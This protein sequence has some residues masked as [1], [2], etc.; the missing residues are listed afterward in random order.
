MFCFSS[1]TIHCFFI[2]LLLLNSSSSFTWSAP[3]LC[4][5][6]AQLLLSSNNSLA[7]HCSTYFPR[8]TT[9]LYISFS[10]F[11]NF[12][13]FSP[14]L[15]F[16]Y[17]ASSNFLW[18]LSL[19]FAFLVVSS[20]AL[21]SFSCS[22]ERILWSSLFAASVF[23]TTVLLRRSFG[24]VP[25]FHQPVWWQ[26]IAVLCPQLSHSCSKKQSTLYGATDSKWTKKHNF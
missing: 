11:Y 14:A 24:T 4:N 22:L 5:C 10:S 8:N 7:H 17:L 2:M 12:S 15:F 16:S 13:L 18:P 20:T 19:S 3:I 9:P 1:P 6:A 26:A 23:C 25:S 21:Q